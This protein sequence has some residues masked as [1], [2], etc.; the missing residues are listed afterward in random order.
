MSV[1]V[2]SNCKKCSDF[3]NKACDGKDGNC[4]CKFCPRDMNICKKVRWCRETESTFV[5]ED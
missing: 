5:V 2:N 4:L 1:V 3:Q